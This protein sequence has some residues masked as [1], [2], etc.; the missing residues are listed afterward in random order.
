[1]PLEATQTS[2]ILN[3][4]TSNNNMADARTRDVGATVAHLSVRI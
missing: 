4:Y 1:M 3:S 2:Y